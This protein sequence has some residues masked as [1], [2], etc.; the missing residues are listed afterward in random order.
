M[1]IDLSYIKSGFSDKL[2]VV[3]YHIALNNLLK[4]K[5]SFNIYEQKNFQCPFK[6]V[7]YCKIRQQKFT[8]IKKKKSLK[9]NIAMNSYNS[10]LNLANCK[11]NNPYKNIDNFRL[12]NEW[13]SSYKKIRPNNN[14]K[15]KIDQ[16]YL[17]S[18]FIGLH[19]RSTDRI[20]N[21]R[22][23]FVDLQLKDMFFQF[24]L[25]NF[26]KNIS[27]LIKKKTS[28][29]NIYIA[30]DEQKSRNKVIK[31]LKNEGFKVYYNNSRYNNNN[32]RKTN[33]KDFLID[34]FCL[35]KS[36]IIFATVGGG[37]PFTASLLSNKSIKTV[38][39]INQINIFIFLRFF[40]LILFYLKRLKSKFF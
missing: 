37:V 13:K 21:F 16:I 11:I 25:K 40:V 12:L 24:Q 32:F 23:F 19:I 5:K 8:K 7:D 33:G 34:L 28:I 39:F 31:N 27:K 6:F 18:K 14:L 35:S 3:T 30:A 10:E 20:I 22:R 15:K 9:S 17:P 38:N 1:F 4:L 29:K 26:E 2:R 36:E